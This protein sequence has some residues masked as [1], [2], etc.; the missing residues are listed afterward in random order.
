MSEHPSVTQVRVTEIFASVQGEASRI[1]LPTVFVRL[2]GCP[3]RCTWCDTEYAFHGG[4][5]RP[6]EDVVAEVAGHGCAK[7]WRSG[8]RRPGRIRR[9][10]FCQSIRRALRG[11]VVKFLA[12]RGIGGLG[13]IERN[14]GGSKEPQ[15]T[16][17]GADHQDFPVDPCDGSRPRAQFQGIGLLRERGWLAHPLLPNRLAR[18]DLGSRLRIR[19]TVWDFSPRRSSAARKR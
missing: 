9:G 14:G 7:L 4:T 1:G 2:T 12:I 16:E 11:R 17:P 6:I 8:R 3:L 10:K 18:P 5:S 19:T 13:R 15:H